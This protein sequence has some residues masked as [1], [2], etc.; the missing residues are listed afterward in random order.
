MRKNLSFLAVAMMIG[1]Y[2]QASVLSVDFAQMTEAEFATWCVLDANN[3][4]KTWVF[5]EDAVPSRVYYTYHSTNMADD[6]LFAPTVTADEAGNYLVAYTIYGSSYGEALEVWT[7][8]GVTPDAMSQLQAT[9]ENIGPEHTTYYFMLDLAA[10]QELTVG[11]H[12]ISNPDKFRLYLENLEIKPVSNP[13]DLRVSNVLTPVTGE[14]LGQ[15][16]V[17][18]EVSNIGLVDIDGFDLCY[19]INGEQLTR[20]HTDMALAV[21]ETATYTFAAPANLSGSRMKYEVKAWTEHPDDFMPSN[22]ASSITVKHIGPASIPYFNGFEDPEETEDFTYLNLNEDEGYWHVATND[23]IIHFSRT[24]DRC[25]G[26]NYDS[27]NDADD[28]AFL[29]GVTMQPGFYVLKYWYSAT[30]GHPE[31]LRVAYGTAPTAEAMEGNTLADYNP[32]MNSHYQEGIHIFEVKEESNIHIGFYCYS[33][34]DEN[35]LLIDDV[36][37]DRVDPTRADLI[38]TEVSKPG[39]YWRNND[40]DEAVVTVQSVSMV[41]A[42]ARLVAYIDGEEA[43]ATPFTIRAQ[44]IMTVTVPGIYANV[45]P[46]S[47]TL[48][49]EVEYADDSNPNNNI[50]EQTVQILGEAKMIWDF[51]DGELPEEFTYRAEDT[52]EIHPDAGEEFNEDGW[53]I[54]NI[55][56]YLLGHHALACC[57][58]FTEPGYVE[59]WLVMPRMHVNGDSHFAWEANSISPLYHEQYRVC[60]SAG[61]DKWWDYN[62]ALTIDDE[63][64]YVA[65]RGI[66]LSQY[67]GQD[68]YVGF[69]IITRDGEALL[70]DNL[71]FYGDVM[72]YDEYIETGVEVIGANNESKAR[73]YNMAGVEVDAENAPAGVYVV[74]RNG[75]ATKVIKR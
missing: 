58:W 46:G 64:E 4:E 61:E 44:E 28:W 48:K 32:M 27:N 25:L 21:G 3:D 23:W 65:T 50:S 62:E 54:F 70:L 49:L 47:H 26:Y 39:A 75:K 18:V 37:I 52:R 34:K 10:G 59:R 15:E 60:V 29:D 11:F 1:S 57:T 19:T 35:W 41:D 12:C 13:V 7:G 69:K 56:H 74:L 17:S 63:D 67:A 71:S 51:E 2:A 8:N 45:T 22:N 66:D 38:L 68:I 5:S 14:G 40:N 9:Y 53:G 42:D 30:E 24:G 43:G 20:E 31:R 73:W 6:W 72:L 55:Q 16:T 36:S 33:N